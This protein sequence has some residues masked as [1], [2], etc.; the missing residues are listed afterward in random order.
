MLEGHVATSQG[1]EMVDIGNGT[2]DA[3]YALTR[4]GTYRVVLTTA[5]Q[6]IS[7]P[8]ECV[9]TTLDP[10]SCEIIAPSEEDLEKWTAGSWLEVRVRR[11][12]RFGNITTLARGG[13]GGDGLVVFADG[14]GAGDVEAE[15]VEPTDAEV[16]EN[17]VDFA[18][19]RFRA[20]VAGEYELAIFAADAASDAY[21]S[22]T[23]NLLPGSGDALKSV[24]LKPAVADAGKSTVRIHGLREKRGRV[25][26]NTL[27]GDA[28]PPRARGRFGD[29]GVVVTV[30][31]MPGALPDSWRRASAACVAKFCDAAS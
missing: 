7:F 31:R 13:G 21:G 23:R 20:T 25:G 4:A 2:Y 29:P 3:T 16:E 14:V 28:G 27:V 24:A 17:G 8:I 12:D 11:R 26:G 30:T 10:P 9:P 6:E 19:A 5:G 1:G 22:R 15:V 18:V